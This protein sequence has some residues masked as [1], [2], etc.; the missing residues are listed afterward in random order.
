MPSPSIPPG[1]QQGCTG[2]IAEGTARRNLER[3]AKGE[4]PPAW[5]QKVPGPMGLDFALAHFQWPGG[6]ST[7]LA[8]SRA[9]A[10]V[11][12]AFVALLRNITY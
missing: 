9:A 5:E 10:R 12:F 4:L 2:K 3:L 8:G 7:A 11:A 6:L 1:L